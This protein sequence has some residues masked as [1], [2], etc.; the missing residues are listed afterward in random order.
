MA[1]CSVPPERFKA[2]LTFN[3]PFTTSVPPLRVRFSADVTLRT[4]AEPPL[5]VIVWLMPTAP[6]SGI[7]TSSPAAGT[8]LAS[9][10]WSCQL[11]AVFPS[12]E[13]PIQLTV[14]INRRSSSR[15]NTSRNNR[16]HRDLFDVRRRFICLRNVIVAPLQL[17]GSSF[18]SCHSHTNTTGR[19]VIYPQLNST[20]KGMLNACLFNDSAINV[21]TIHVKR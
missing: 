4:V 3:S 2:P 13:P 20:E 1:F 19:C 14:A 12:P 10:V 17:S 9:V 11:S 8:R 16:R 6:T 18:L 21:P 15:S 7:T 5:N